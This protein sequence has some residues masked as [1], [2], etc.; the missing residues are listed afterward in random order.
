MW[1]WPVRGPGD[2]R[3]LAYLQ[4]HGVPLDFF[5]WHLYSNKP[6]DYRDAARFY[7]QQLDAHGYTEAES[8]ITEW[9]F[10][11]RGASGNGLWP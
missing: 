10:I 3:Q 8:H 11:F 9:N 4:S 7:R 1:R 2:G 5:S 6:E